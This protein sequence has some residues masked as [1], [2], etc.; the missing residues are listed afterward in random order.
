MA[1]PLA[2]RIRS[3][4]VEASFCFAISRRI[5]ALSA[6]LASGVAAWAIPCVTARKVKQRRNSAVWRIFG[7]FMFA[8]RPFFEAG[9]LGM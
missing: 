5:F 3:A 7:R 2:S 6:I 8:T 9:N 1:M 4:M